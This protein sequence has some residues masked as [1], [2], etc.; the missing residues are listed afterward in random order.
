MG[1]ISDI[2]YMS[3]SQVLYL[4]KEFGITDV[5][6]GQ[7]NKGYYFAEGNLPGDMKLTVNDIIPP[8]AP[9]PTTP[10]QPAPPRVKEQVSAEPRIP[11]SGKVAQV[12]AWLDQHGNGMDRKSAIAALVATGVNKSTASVQ[13]SVWEKKRGMK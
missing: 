10:K 3:K 12:H 9:T 6:V 5:V 11:G 4:A 7:D 1:K 2:R 8:T 13:Y